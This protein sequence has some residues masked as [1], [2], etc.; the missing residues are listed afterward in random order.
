MTTTFWH[1]FADMF[2][3][4]DHE[5]ILSSATGARVRDRDGNEYIDATGG[6]WYCSVGYGRQ[7]I[8][9]AVAEQLTKLAA[10]SAFGPYATE[11]TIELAD[12]LAATA[13]VPD[14]VVF[15]TSGGSDAVETAAKLVR[16]YW[17]LNGYP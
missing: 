10:Y 4:K 5:V 11:P 2:A 15:F 12:L 8:A 13:P 16:R 14:A 3:T 6:L 9:T 7:E 17:D 1:P